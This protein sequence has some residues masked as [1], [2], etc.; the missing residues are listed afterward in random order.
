MIIEIVNVG[1]VENKGKY[2]Q[3]EVIYKDEGG[4]VGTKKLMSFSFPDVFNTL[5]AGARGVSYAVEL[6]KN[7]KGYWDWTKVQPADEPN[8]NTVTEPAKKAVGG[9]VTGSNYETPEEREWRQTRIGRQA[10]LNSAI[11]LL[12]TDKIVPPKDDVIGLATELETWVNR[13]TF[14]QKLE[15][16]PDDIIE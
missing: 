10:C 12:K 16:M 2:S 13:K 4:K 3:V 8:G 15:E 9:R 11:A 1:A 7:D 14:T 5:K 6:V